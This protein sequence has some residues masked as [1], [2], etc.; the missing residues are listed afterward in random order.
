MS[1][2]LFK[3]EEYSKKIDI[4]ALGCF[5]FELMVFKPP[6]QGYSIRQL[7]SAV[8]KEKYCKNIDT[9]RYSKELRNIIKKILIKDM[10]SRPNIDNILDIVDIKNKIDDILIK[11]KLKGYDYNNNDIYDFDL[12]FNNV[13][14]FIWKDIIEKINK[15]LTY[16]EKKK[17]EGT[18]RDL[19]NRPTSNSNLDVIKEESNTLNVSNDVL[20]ENNDVLKENNDVLKENNDVF[21]GK[22]DNINTLQV[23]KEMLSRKQNLSKSR[24]ILSKNELNKKYSVLPEIKKKDYSSNINNNDYKNN[25]NNNNNYKNNNNNNN[26]N[27]YNNRY[28]CNYKYNFNSRF[29][30]RYIN[31]KNYDLNISRYE[32]NK[33]ITKNKYNQERYDIKNKNSNTNFKN[34]Y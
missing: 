30:N 19:L 8:R 22:D 18:K 20:K 31:S 15:E 5:L 21:K 32:N 6:F 4:W 29:G 2:E 11:H 27:I 7:S 16:K 28:N 26:N 10:N 33:K 24:N 13:D 25:K 23:P 17:I 3:H 1:P 9:L 34:F 12:K 14:Y